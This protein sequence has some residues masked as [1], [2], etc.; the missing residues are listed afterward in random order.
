M[1]LN[2]A[3]RFVQGLPVHCACLGVLLAAEPRDPPEGHRNR[4]ASRART[5]TCHPASWVSVCQCVCVRVLC[6]SFLSIPLC[7]MFRVCDCP[8]S[9]SELGAGPGTVSPPLSVVSQPRV[10]V[11]STPVSSLKHQVGELS[12]VY[13]AANCFAAETSICAV[14]DYHLD[15]MS[16]A[17]VHPHN[18]ACSHVCICLS[19]ECVQA[20]SQATPSGSKKVKKSEPGPSSVDQVCGILVC[21][22]V[23]A[24][25]L[26]ATG[27][28][29]SRQGDDCCLNGM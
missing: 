12:M 18:N 25:G 7:K 6:C 14:V 27:F 10:E 3:C 23:D 4:Q 8:M 1:M 5:C 15:Y 28:V 16:L 29:D 20:P 9:L 2:V 17:Y 22:G 26:D 13:P 11:T 21:G 19:C 24:D